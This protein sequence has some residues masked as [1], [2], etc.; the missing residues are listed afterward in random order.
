MPGRIHQGNEFIKAIFLP[1]D[2]AMVVNYSTIVASA[3][4]IFSKRE[5]K[6]ALVRKIFGI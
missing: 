4:F 2:P 1:N 3:N 6:S 5:K